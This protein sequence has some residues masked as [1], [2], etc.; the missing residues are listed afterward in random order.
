MS[1]ETASRLAARIRAEGP[2]PLAAF[3]GEA[4]AAYYRRERVFGAAGD[5]VTAPEISQIFGE[6]IGIWFA[7]RWH[8]AGRPARFPLVECGPGRGAL[9]SDALRAARS[10]PG[11]ADA[12]ELHL[13]E[14]SPT[15]AAAQAEALAGF[16]AT[17]HADL[18]TLPDGPLHLVANEFLDALPVTQ[19]VF[20]GGAWRE[21]RVGLFRQDFAFVDGP[22]AAPPAEM[23]SRLPPPREGEIFE[24]APAAESFVATVAARIAASG[25]AALVFDYGHAESG[26][27]DTVQAVSRHRYVQPL[28][29][30]GEVDLT[31]HVDFARIAETARAHGAAAFG[32]AD[33]GV[34]LVAMGLPTRLTVLLRQATPEQTEELVAGTRRLTEPHAMGRL[35]KT[36]ALLPVSAAPPEGF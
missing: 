31:A 25:G 10:V 33:Q 29:D 22:E 7:L 28:A 30:P 23:L 15:L 24:T 17:W 12:I 32:P 19:F 6:L 36:L 5:F 26:F 2:M 8:A 20:R 13:V 21:R 9:I 27:G 3:M 34:W 18:E 14:T 35:F 1:G 16:P 4:V 11:F